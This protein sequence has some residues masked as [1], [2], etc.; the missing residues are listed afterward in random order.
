VSNKRAVR[1]FLNKFKQKARTW[2]V[3]FKDER[4]KNKQALLD[5]EITPKDRKDVLF[6]LKAEDY[7]EGPIKD[8]L[9]IGSGLWVFGKKVESEEV[10]IKITLGK[11]SRPVICISFHVAEHNMSYPLKKRE[12]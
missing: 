8:E 6:D 12:D 1:Q 9:D 3:I 4:K 7:S 2:R 11:R 5:L 10:Y